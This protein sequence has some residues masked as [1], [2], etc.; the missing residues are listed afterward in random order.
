MNNNDEQYGS[1][2]EESAPTAE[3]QKPKRGRPTFEVTWPKTEFTAEEVY[4][5]LENKLSRVSVHA[6]IN[7][8]ISSGELVTVGKIKPKT[9]R[10]KMVY[11]LAA[12]RDSIYE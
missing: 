2:W 4:K 10:P 11:K 7:R 5:S 12:S 8:A 9:G 1:N 6:K 3:K